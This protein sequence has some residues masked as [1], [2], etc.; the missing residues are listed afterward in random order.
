MNETCK[1]CAKYLALTGTELLY[2]LWVSMAA[3]F[4]M[5]LVFGIF[6][7]W[8]PSYKLRL[9]RLLQDQPSPCSCKFQIFFICNETVLSF[10][11]ILHC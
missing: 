6:R 11:V 2:R 5:L 9:V 1:N 8:V 4:F 3:G 7:R 10:L